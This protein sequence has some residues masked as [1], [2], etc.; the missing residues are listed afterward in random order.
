LF[1]VQA[2]KVGSLN[3][4]VAVVG[5]SVG[6]PT[7][8]RNNHSILILDCSVS[9]SGSI[10]DLREDSQEYVSELGEKDFVSIIIFS[11]H[12]RARLIAGPTQCNAAGKL[13]LKRAIQSDV[14]V[15]DT[16]V[17]SEPLELAIATVKKL[18]GLGTVHNAVLFTDG[19]PVPTKWSGS[20]EAVRSCDAASVLSNVG[21][22]VSV[23][24]YGVYYDEKFINRLILAAGNEGIFRHISEIENFGAVIKHIRDT[25]IKTV[26]SDI[27]LNFHSDKGPTGR[28]F[29][30]TPQL[31]VSSGAGKIVM[32]GLY[33]GKATLFIELLGPC[34]S[35][36]I[37]GKVNGK[38]VDE[39]IRPEKLSDENVV[40][41]IRTLGAAAFL[42]GNY[43]TAAE[44]LNLVS[45]EWL[46]EKIASAL[47]TREQRETAD[48]CRRYFIDR[49]FIGAGLKPTGPSH[50]VL[51]VIRTLI[52]D[53]E[54]VVSIPAGA[55]KRSG[56]LTADPQVIESPLGRTLQVLGYRSHEDRFNFSFLALKDIK[57]RPTNG[58]RPVDMQ[59]WRTY[60]V[61]LDGNLH[62]P[63]F[64][65]SLT[66]KS[67]NIL[68][69]AGVIEDGMYVPGKA[70]TV[71]L[72]GLKMISPNWANPA[73]LGLV[74]LLKEEAHL[75][76][77]QTALNA[78]CK[79]LKPVVPAATTDLVPGGIYNP[80][81]AVVENV[82][83]EYYTAPCCE[84]RLMKYK[85]VPFDCSAMSFEE[86]N[87]KVRAV[88]QRLIVVRF[89]IRA[90]TFAMEMVKSG[91]IKWDAGKTTQRGQYP[92][93]EQS[94]IFQGAELKRVIWEEQQA[95]S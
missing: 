65:A 1:T 26:I 38:T 42:D 23:I 72:R 11:G 61:V 87:E 69:E 14:K 62:M 63:E 55:Y 39:T 91:T 68:K 2:G 50:C 15:L 35:I 60:N 85:P 3:K 44:M 33:E 7:E 24:G 30:T 36:K 51:N 5:V 49:K 20:A 47:T 88:R 12:G 6:I 18:T 37:T 70:Y 25:F 54:N 52:E 34:S 95:C 73:S 16:T 46:A 27:T 19:C 86:A 83:V 29:K 21:C 22:V 66:E 84:Y 48:T 92:K 8:I 41:Y 79:V 76:V 81:S 93:L 59:M 94:T 31:F 28:I 53:P 4:Y 78:R 56:L 67:F 82:P 58:G 57:V 90:I 71:N 74:N 89:L 17:F 80:K 75:E 64:Q 45:D 13:M 43:A 10:N 9:M 40:D 77:Q 32:K